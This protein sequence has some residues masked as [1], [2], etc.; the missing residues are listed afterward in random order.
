MLGQIDLDPASCAR[1]QDVVKA[2]HY[3]VRED[4]SLQQGQAY[5]ARLDAFFRTQGGFSCHREP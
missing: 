5:V 2:G 1:A 4:D 3:W